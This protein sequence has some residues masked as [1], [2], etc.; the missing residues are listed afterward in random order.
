MKYIGKTIR[1]FRTVLDMR[2]RL[3][4]ECHITFTDGTRIRIYADSNADVHVQELKPSKKGATDARRTE[5]A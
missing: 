1:S 3:Y 5:S 2:K 4:K